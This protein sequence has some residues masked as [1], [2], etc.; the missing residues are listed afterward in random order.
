MATGTGTAYT[1]RRR[2]ALSSAS[3]PST[4][5]PARSEYPASPMAPGA[6]SSSGTR[7]RVGAALLTLVVT[8]CATA[9]YR[10]DTPHYVGPSVGSQLRGVGP[11]RRKVTADRQALVGGLEGPGLGANGKSRGRHRGLQQDYS[12]FGVENRARVTAPGQLASQQGL[13]SRQETALHRR[14]NPAGSLDAKGEHNSQGSQ[15][16]GQRTERSAAR[17]AWLRER[18]RERVRQRRASLRGLPRNRFRNR[19]S[20]MARAGTF[21]GGW[22]QAEAASAELPAVHALVQQRARLQATCK[23][24]GLQ[25]DSP[26]LRS[27][28][29]TGLPNTGTNAV[30]KFLGAALKM[31]V[32]N[33]IPG[34]WK[35]LLPFQADMERALLRTCGGS[36]E[37]EPYGVVFTVRHPVAWLSSQTSPGHNFGHRCSSTPSTSCL[38]STCESHAGCWRNFSPGYYRFN[39]LVDL[40]TGYV[41]FLP[42]LP[43]VYILRYEDF[44]HDPEDALLMIAQ[45]FNLSHQNAEVG[46]GMEALQHSARPWDRHQQDAS[47]A[48]SLSKWQMF[49]RFW[50][51]VQTSRRGAP[52]GDVPC[53]HDAKMHLTLPPRTQQHLSETSGQY[54]AL[55]RRYNYTQVTQADAQFAW[56]LCKNFRP[57]SSRSSSALRHGV[58][59]W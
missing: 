3:A 50:H 59:R 29:V 45:R 53:H 47:L 2:P 43:R 35:H 5:K 44:L 51:Q 40:W 20:H 13:G 11:G 4:S 52:F 28:A 57:S 37:T 48:N 24:S 27:L 36:A 30:K 38:F 31:N 9:A 56:D 18:V 23:A 54:Q 34:L 10:G 16:N 41:T 55:L 1:I 21:P 49:S 12:G 15:A 39:S 6:R 46:A 19:R 14:G 25:A 42:A 33:G 7:R 17:Q 26:G 8:C 22:K 32:T 58:G